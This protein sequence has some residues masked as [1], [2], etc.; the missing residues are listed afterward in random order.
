MADLREL[1]EVI[2]NSIQSGLLTADEAGRILYLNIFGEGI[3]GLRNLDAR[4]RPLQEVF[5][6]DVLEPSTLHVRAATR[7]LARLELVYRH[8]AGRAGGPR[9]LRL[10]AGDGSI[11]AAA[12]SCSCSR[13]SP[14]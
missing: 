2:V 8:P 11:P 5:G 3:L 12:G 6:S 9:R 4:G 10:Q 1:N 7:R 14:T 13:T